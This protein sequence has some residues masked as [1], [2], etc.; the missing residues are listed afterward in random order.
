MER[1]PLSS[2][3]MFSVVARLL[4]VSRAADELN[5]TPS[6]VSHHIKAL[7]I[8][9]GTK[10][11]R[12]V[13]NKIALTPAGARYAAEVASGM[14]LLSNAT[15]VLKAAGDQPPLCISCPPSLALL[16]L[17]PRV[18][19]FMTE[20][21]A[22][23]LS[24][25]MSMQ[26]QAIADG[27]FDVH[28]CYGG[29]GLSGLRILPLGRNKVFPICSPK[30][31]GCGDLRTTADLAQHTILDSSDETFYQQRDRHPGWQGW[32]E[33]AGLP[34]I[35]GTRYLNFTPWVCMHTA[36][37]R[38]LGVGLSQTLLALDDMLTGEITVPF[39]PVID[40]LTSY[41]LVY[42]NIMAKRSEVVAFSDWLVAEAKDSIR[43]VEALLPAPIG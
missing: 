18:E 13:G 37:K 19:K 29:A 2:V 15:R 20:N 36:V 25:T 41:N 32:L 43:Q 14:L 3:R 9:V 28:V 7:E 38:G 42:P 4:S 34:E 6:A 27:S 23:S 10:L 31:A 16:W 33:A 26:R 39:G 12:R 5:V 8:Y 24:V 22:L 30:M 21:P 11:V 1:L 17:I 40:T 35:V